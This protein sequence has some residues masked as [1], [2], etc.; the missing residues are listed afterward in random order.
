LR[1]GDDLKCAPLC[2]AHHQRKDYFYLQFRNAC[3]RFETAFSQEGRK[4]KL[5]FLRLNKYFFRILAHLP[6]DSTP[7][8]GIR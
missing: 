5:P 1:D 6:I 8:Q 2:F 7:Q 3:G 4:G